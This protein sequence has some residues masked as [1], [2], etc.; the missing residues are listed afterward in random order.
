[1]RE[2]SDPSVEGQVEVHLLLP[3]SDFTHYL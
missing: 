3:S 2:E 1:M